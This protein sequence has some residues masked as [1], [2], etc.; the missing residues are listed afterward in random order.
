MCGCRS[1]YFLAKSYVLL[2]DNCVF[3]KAA[4]VVA[5]VVVAAVV[6]VV[7][8]VAV[9]VVVAVAAWPTSS[10]GSSSASK[11]ASMSTLYA[12]FHFP[13]NDESS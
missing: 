5:A 13:G 2:P 10:M 11:P 4:V 12:G 3:G 9:V 8:A 1:N 6:V 7:A